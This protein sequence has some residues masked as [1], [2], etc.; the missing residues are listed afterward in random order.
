MIQTKWVLNG[1][2]VPV[3]LYFN[4]RIKIDWPKPWPPSWRLIKDEVKVMDGWQWNKDKKEWTI[5][6]SLRNMRQLAQLNYPCQWENPYTHDHPTT[7]THPD[8]QYRPDQAELIQFII[9]HAGKGLGV[10]GA[11]DM[12][13]GKSLATFASL[14]ELKQQRFPIYPIWLFGPKNAIN[15]SWH[16]QWHQWK[17]QLD[18][19]QILMTN[20]EQIKNVMDQ[21]SIPPRTLVLDESIYVKNPKTKRAM[22]IQSIVKHMQ[23]H[24]GKDYLIILLCGRPA[25]RVPGD[26]WNQVEICYEGY[27]RESSPQLLNKRCGKWE[28]IDEGYGQYPKLIGWI[29]E[30][31]EA[32]YR[33]L[34]KGPVLFSTV[35]ENR[36]YLLREIE[37]TKEALDSIKL[38][39]DDEDTA[40]GKLTKLRQVS[41]GFIYTRSGDKTSASYF[42]SPKLEAFSNDLELLI[43]NGQNRIVVFAGFT[44]SVDKC[45][46]E[47]VKA[48]WNVIRV[49]SRGWHWFGKRGYDTNFSRTT[50][51]REN[52]LY[53]L[54]QQQTLQ[55]PIAIIGHTGSIG[56]ALTLPCHFMLFYSNDFNPK[57]R[58][59][60]E[61][62]SRNPNVTI[63]DY[64]YLPQDYLV[65]NT[66]KRG[67]TLQG[68]SMGQIFDEEQ[69]A[70][71]RTV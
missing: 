13:R 18:Q 6:H 34:K 64:A 47:A 52:H 9:N 22:L 12:G 25:P 49:D 23:N 56:E 68:L 27:L 11:Y 39:R 61:A 60:A 16:Q 21:E 63:I 71:V 28:M 43:H 42:G 5:T 15:I 66:L 69:L 51:R 19:S 41:D 48:G 26:W 57:N 44:A 65:I 40:I 50:G 14:E 17:P 29:P 35:K 54:F 59:Q 67:E 32:L 7:I 4:D 38:I 30:E 45:T 10:I 24:Y 33:R 55:I 3:N 2:A 62:R 1:K 46:E 70:L 20:Y 58:Q 36:T 8:R 31:I 37:P 53:H